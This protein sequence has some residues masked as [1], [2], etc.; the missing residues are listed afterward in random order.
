LTLPRPCRKFFI[1]PP[2]RTTECDYYLDSLSWLDCRGINGLVPFGSY[3]W[4][5]V[6]TVVNSTASTNIRVVATSPKE[7]LPSGMDDEGATQWVAFSFVGPEAKSASYIYWDP[8]AGIGYRQSRW[9]TFV[10]RWF[11]GWCCACGCC[12]TF[13]W[14]CRVLP[15]LQENEIARFGWKVEQRIVDR[16]VV[17]SCTQ[18]K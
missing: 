4:E 14:V 15:G 17:P 18:L 11:D 16:S 12:C 10:S 8:E 2:S 6:A 9:T 13:S 3:T 1:P 5:T 7:P